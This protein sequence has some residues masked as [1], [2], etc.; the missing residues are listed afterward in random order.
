[1]RTLLML[2]L[3]LAV[4]A[5]ASPALLAQSQ[6]P[7]DHPRLT[8]SDGVSL[9][10]LMGAPFDSTG[11]LTTQ[12]GKSLNLSVTY[13]SEGGIN[14]SVAW[15]LLLSADVTP[16]PLTQI[17]PPLFTLP[18]FRLI[19]PPGGM[20]DVFGEGELVV[21]LPTGLVDGSAFLQVI[22]QDPDA[23]TG[24]PLRLSNGVR[25]DIGP[26][27]YNVAF[28][29]IRAIPGLGVAD[30]EGVASRDIG[31]TELNQQAPFG[32]TSAPDSETNDV[33]DPEFRFLPIFPTDVE[34]PIVPVLTRPTTLVSDPI[35]A[36]DDTELFVEDTMGFPSA[37]K[38]YLNVNA[39]NLYANKANQGS[40]SPD[41]EVISY[42]GK[43][44]TSFTGLTRKLLGSEGQASYPHIAEAVVLG[45]HS[46][47]STANIIARDSVGLDARNT[48]M[49]RV[50]VPAFTF[51]PE[52][53]GGGG[54][55][56]PDPVTREI[57]I[58]RYEISA[59]GAQ[60]FALLD[61][62]THEF[63]LIPGTEFLPG[64]GLVWDPV[65]TVTPD[66]R[67][68]L[69]TLRVSTGINAN[70]PSDPDRLFAIRLDGLDWPATSPAA[71]VWEI[72]YELDDEPVDMMD[73]T[74]RSRA[75]VPESFVVLNQDSEQQ[76]AY[77]GLAHKFEKS[78]FG[79]NIAEFSGEIVGY[80]AF[81]AREETLVRDLVEIPL[82]APGSEIT[83]PLPTDRMPWISDEFPPM[84]TSEAVIRF[85]PYPLASP[86][87]DMLA[88]PAGRSFVAEDMYVIRNVVIEPDGSVSRFIFNITGFGSLF[89]SGEDS[90]AVRSLSPT[91][92]AGTG[93]RLAFSPDSSQLAWVSQQNNVR[94][95][96]N[97]ASTNGVDYGQVNDI[98]KVTVQ[99]STA[100]EFLEGEPF[101]S[102][103]VLMQL[104]WIGNEEV[105]FS[106]G[107]YSYA[108]PLFLSNPP[109][110]PRM[111][112]YSY[113]LQAET[114]SNVSRTHSA[115]GD[116]DSYG[117]MSLLT[118]WEST[119]GR[120][121]YYLRSGEISSGN[122]V[123]P[124]GTV[125][126]NII[127][128][129][130]VAGQMVDVT[131]DEFSDSAAL[132]N[133][134]A[135]QSGFV[136]TFE[137]PA[138]YGFV[139]GTGVQEHNMWFSAVEV[140]DDDVIDQIFNYRESSPVLGFQATTSSIPGSSVTNLVPSAYTN[141]LAYARTN[142]P[143]PF[144]NTQH[145]YIVDAD[146]FLFVRDLAP[147]VMSGGTPFGRV[148]D[149]SFRFIAPTVEAGEGFVFSFGLGTLEPGAIAT[150]TG[151]F[152]LAL[153]NVS[154]PALEPE[155]R[156]ISLVDTLPLTLLAEVR[157]YVMS[158]GPS[159]D[160]TPLSP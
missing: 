21:P 131:G 46:M 135:S 115:P 129:D 2:S 141:K 6:M 85:D 32:F 98:Y 24:P 155:P 67:A 23:M 146:A 20:L 106:M 147:S 9:A 75:L 40:N 42:T 108:D 149:G 44:A 119:D 142:G 18:P 62:R 87:R 92:G 112:I 101:T 65:I 153:D 68:F 35:T 136:G 130:R 39:N 113:S 19:L 8:A 10:P 74:V 103:A 58:L 1:M 55:G 144:G 138:E 86:N 56:T 99:G 5:G 53:G 73:S 97:V 80:E 17:P 127:A 125:V 12:G 139:L 28:S 63:E 26:P 3:V 57:D 76:V 13:L 148:M 137:A 102:S 45:D 38:L 145:P 15:G 31:P 120:Y 116:F 110:A 82:V 71:P 133:L 81:Y 14:D 107:P 4:V 77:V 37:G 36:T 79:D 91:R 16:F 154:N 48:D 90:G 61:H 43:T 126:T 134:R 114:I 94:D 34:G 89:S 52:P 59:S 157:L 11:V 96:L 124:P 140:F 60:G 159:A 121:V 64:D 50:T 41:V 152:Y 122:T 30:L 29:F 72:L 51:T 66:H 84:G 33:F 117:S 143:D 156:V 93:R 118:S 105:L 54:E 100:L 151:V 83:A 158:A 95:W 22:V 47:I 78:N 25:V 128:Y 69:A 7:G 132:P 27:D 150:S 111:D 160:S 109:L 88:I 104:H 123:L 49:P 70:F